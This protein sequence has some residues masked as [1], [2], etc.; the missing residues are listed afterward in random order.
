VGS[1]LGSS[2]PR[3]SQQQRSGP[4]SVTCQSHSSSCSFSCRCQGQGHWARSSERV[5]PRLQSATHGLLQ[6]WHICPGSAQRIVWM[7]KRYTMVEG[8]L[9]HRGANSILMRCITQKESRDLLAEVHGGECGS[10]S[11][12]RTLVG[13]AFRH[14]FYWPTALQD[15][16]ELVRSCKACQFHA[17]QI[18]T[19]AQALQMISPSW[20]FAVWGLDILGPFSR[21]VGGYRYL[22]VAIDKSPSGRRQPQLSTSPRHQQLP[23]SSQLCASS[24]SR[25]GSS[26]TMGLSSRA[27]TSKSTTRTSASSFVS[28]QW[29]IPGAMAK[30]SGLMLRSLEGLRSGPTAILKNMAQN[31][32]ISFRACYGEP[33][34]TQPGDWGNLFLLGLRG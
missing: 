25:T 6:P 11:S 23:S 29:R 8:D 22:Y 14:V 4:L 31:G 12:S 15:A 24:G 26:P 13:K 20:A 3:S 21:A 18:H 34:H 32:L 2:D 16:A 9:Y 33:D 27:N 28:P 1:F 17:K 30:S 7:A 10:H 5:L 19:P